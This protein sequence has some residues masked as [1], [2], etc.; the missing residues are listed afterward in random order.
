MSALKFLSVEDL[1][2]K[3]IGFSRQHRHRLIHD[4]KFP[5]PVKIGAAT[6]AFVETEID[7]WIAQKIAERDARKAT[8]DA[9]TITDEKKKTQPP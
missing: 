3:G 7:E 1:Y 6:N 8:R 4:G 5:T 2:A 9:T